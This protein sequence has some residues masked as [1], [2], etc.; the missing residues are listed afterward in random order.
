MRKLI[1]TNSRGQSIELTNAEPY[2]LQKFDAGGFKNKVQTQKAPFQDGE[3]YIDSLAEKRDPYLEFMILAD[4]ENILN[5]RKQ[6]VNSIF[7]PKLGKGKLR[8][9]YDSGS[10]EIE[11]VIEILSFPIGEK[12]K[13][14][15]FQK[16][17]VNFMAPLPFWLDTFVES[18][19]MADWLGG[20]SFGL[21]LPTM[22]AGRSSRQNKVIHNAGDVETPIVFEFMGVATNPKIIN[23]DTGEYIKVNRTIGN[24]EKLIITTEFGNKK[25]ILKNLITGE[26]ANA[27]GWIDLGSTFFQ[28]SSGD[29]QLSYDADAGKENAKVWIRWRNRYVGV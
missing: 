22:F 18:E 17:V 12:N 3:T 19:E 26:E 24:D 25:V 20:F 8:Y 1:Y 15:H 4:S 14:R 23:I 21:Q 28:L 27:F 7:N 29:N 6:Y 13:G 9:E 11:T 16:V 2:I 10:K 5:Q